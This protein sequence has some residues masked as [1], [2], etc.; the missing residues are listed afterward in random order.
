MRPV[1]QGS[2]TSAQ[3][4]SPLNA[5]P[6]LNAPSLSNIRPKPF[7]PLDE[8]SQG[9]S[10]NGDPSSQWQSQNWSPSN[11]RPGSVQNP[12]MNHVNSMG[13]PGTHPSDNRPSRRPDYPSYPAE[14]YPDEQ[15]PDEQY[16]EYPDHQYPQDYPEQ[17]YPD[18]YQEQQ[19]PDE[20]EEVHQYTKRPMV[21][22]QRPTESSGGGFLT[23]L[24]NLVG[25][26]LI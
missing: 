19:Y 11:G 18:E 2:A 14:Q 4:S 20:Y 8:I 7:K 17:Q 23:K 16:S 12:S 22:Q 21:Q 1:S 9:D 26:L 25:K 15:Y 6:Q 10:S 13:K 5:H 3:T 24:V